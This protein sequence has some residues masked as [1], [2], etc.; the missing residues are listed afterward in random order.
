M[1]LYY[2]DLATCGLDEVLLVLL[3]AV[4]LTPALLGPSPAP[5]LTW[6]REMRWRAGERTAGG[7]RP[8]QTRDLRNHPVK[9]DSRREQHS[10]AESECKD[11]T[12][13]RLHCSCACT[14]LT[15]K[16]LSFPTKM[17]TRA[18][19]GL[20][21][22]FCFHFLYFSV[23]SKFYNWGKVLFLKSNFLNSNLLSPLMK[24]NVCSVPSG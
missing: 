21:G 12:P 5:G 16:A 1:C 2:K 22:H 14:L 19:T 8:G 7:G 20:R 3:N 9:W 23:F 17:F 13:P 4:I 10:P 24:P 15:T 18:G 11:L 6:P